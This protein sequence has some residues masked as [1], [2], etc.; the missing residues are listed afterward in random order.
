MMLA[1]SVV[2]VISAEELTAIADTIV[3]RN[4][5]SFE[6]YF[7]VTGI[8][9]AH[10]AGLP[11]SLRG[12]STGCAVRGAGARTRDPR[13]H[14]RRGSVPARGGALDGAAGRCSPS[15]AAASS[16]WSSP[17][18][19]S[20][21]CAPAALHRRRLHQAVPGHAAADAALPRLFRLPIC[22][23][24]A[25]IAWPA[26]ALGAHASMPAPSSAR[27]GA[28]ASRRSR[29]A[30]GRRRG[31]SALGYLPQLALVILPQ[32]LR[33]AHPADGRLPG[34]AAEG[35]VARLDHR[36]HRAHARRRRWST[37]PR[38]GRSPSTASSRRS[39]SCCAGRSRLQP[40][41]GKAAWPGAA[42]PGE[43][44]RPIGESTMEYRKLGRSGLKVSPLCLGAMM[45]GGPADEATVAAHDRGGTRCRHQLHRHRRR[46]QRRQVR[47]GDRPRHPGRARPL[48]D[49]HQAQR[50]DGRPAQPAR[51]VAQW[52][53]EA[54]RGS[55]A[56]LGTDYI[57]V[58]YLHREDLE[59]PLEES[60]QRWAISC[61]PG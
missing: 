26:A 53:F 5:R 43:A 12:S 27:S 51:L 11:G 42:H 61:A 58:Y 10:G 60:V 28:A 13:I 24:A 47:G 35:H 9:L 18:C 56:R 33:I 3:A 52:I 32:A 16:G 4:F 45:F 46:L 59:T 39:I 19:A 15:S 34:A 1:S 23:A 44:R 6:F 54:A 41:A 20:R 40:A 38:S 17:S 2:S 36:L 57:D 31:R 49:R 48:G 25:P 21:K 8:Y 14:D 29:A 7:V 37:T 30:N 55:L 22:S 50:H